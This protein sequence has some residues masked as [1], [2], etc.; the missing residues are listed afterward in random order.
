MIYRFSI[1]ITGESYAPLMNEELR[2]YPLHIYSN[3]TKDD[4]YQIRG[5]SHCYG[6]GGS[7]ILH[8]SIFAF[9][10]EERTKIIEDYLNFLERNVERLKHY[11][12]TEFEI[13]ATIY[14]E[15]SKRFLVM[16]RDEMARLLQCGN[17]S[18]RLD[19]ICL[20][21]KDYKNIQNS[22]IIERGMRYERL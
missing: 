1:F 22:M 6:Y 5:H 12:A 17:I 7:H 4:T 21:T 15:E 11:G 10:E 16:T 8:N 18:F 3:W 20:R 2:N 14:M 13:A 9:S 19:I